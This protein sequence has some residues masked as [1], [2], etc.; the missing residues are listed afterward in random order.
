MTRPAL[1]PPFGITSVPLTPKKPFESIAGRNR[2]ASKLCAEAAREKNAKVQARAAATVKLR[3]TQPRSNHDA[4][5]YG[6]H[7]RVSMLRGRDVSRRRYISRSRAAARRRIVGAF[8][9]LGR[10]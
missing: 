10:A 6:W 3:I 5:D 9:G 8:S 7:S 2:C 4:A 1:K